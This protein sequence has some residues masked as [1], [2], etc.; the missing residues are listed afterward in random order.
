MT[1]KLD[2]NDKDL[3]LA[4]PDPVDPKKLTKENSILFLEDIQ[5][6]FGSKQVLKDIHL[7]VKKK[8]TISIL[9]KS[10]TGKS[11][12]LK[13]IIGLLKPDFGEVYAFQEEI[14]GMN[15]SQLEKVRQRMGFLF[16]GGALYDSM[17][18]RENL[19]FPLERQPDKISEA[20]MEE[21]AENVLRE[22]SLLDAID[23]MPSELSGGM[24]KRIALART[25]I[26]SPEII[27]YDEPTTGLDPATS[28]EISELI[29]KMQEKFDV[30]SIVVTHDMPCAKIVSS[31]IKI[32][33]D[34]TFFK[35]GTFD[36][37]EKSDDEFVKGFF[38]FY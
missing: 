1:D 37:L 2:Q 4:P 15:R 26:L 35:E 11:V 23:K 34:G 29:V 6:S 7:A 8:E 32:L 25:L 13:C 33:K 18:V 10:G 3:K 28:K 30:T 38:E 16:Q 14:T 20:E 17:T 5:K 22:V 12:I 27:L 24:L 21:K 31:R 9:G 36:E 19:K